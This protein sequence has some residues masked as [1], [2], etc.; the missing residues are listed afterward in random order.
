MAT[1][2]IFVGV[3]GYLAFEH[4]GQNNVMTLVVGV[5]LYLTVY[6]AVAYLFSMNEYEKGLLTGIIK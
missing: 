2:L 4:L 5:L 1:P 3:A 6:G